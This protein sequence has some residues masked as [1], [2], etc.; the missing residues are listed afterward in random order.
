L[1]FAAALPAAAQQTNIEHVRALI[2]QAQQAGAQTPAPATQSTPYV[3]EGPRVDLSIQDAVARALEKNID[4]AVARITPRLTDFTLAG[5]EAT[6]R[7]NLTAATSEQH[8]T[9]LPTL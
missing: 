4:I 6:Y 1:V 7:L 3:T 8:N 2:A 9:Q 5:L